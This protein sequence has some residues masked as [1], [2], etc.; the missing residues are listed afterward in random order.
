MASVGIDGDGELDGCTIV[1]PVD[2]SESFA[3]VRFE[4]F[5]D[6]ELGIV[7]DGWGRS[8]TVSTGRLTLHVKVN[9]GFRKFFEQQSKLSRTD[10]TCRTLSFQI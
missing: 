7:T 3:G 4:D 9:H 1:P 8:A 5:F 2:S 6:D 10:S